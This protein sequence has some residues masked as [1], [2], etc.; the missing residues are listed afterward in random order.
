MVINF[1]FPN[2]LLPYLRFISALTVF[3]FIGFLIF[4][5]ITAELN[6][7]MYADQ[8]DNLD[9][10]CSTDVNEDFKYLKVIS[11]EKA[12]NRASVYCVYEDS[13]KNLRLDLNYRESEWQVYLTT[14]LN[15]KRNL[16]WPIYL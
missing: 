5:Y 7:R 16:Y 11:Y 4:S 12:F 10:L 8:F 9:L 6:T 13:S 2:T 3:I 15:K 1:K 14:R